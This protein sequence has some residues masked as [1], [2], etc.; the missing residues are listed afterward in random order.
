MAVDFRPS[1]RPTLGVEWE[2]GLVDAGTSDDV[3]GTARRVTSIA[4]AVNG[5]R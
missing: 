5:G 3:P 2:L 4:N 1:R